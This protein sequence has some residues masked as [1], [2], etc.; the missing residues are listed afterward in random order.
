MGDYPVNVTLI[1]SIISINPINLSLIESIKAMSKRVTLQDIADLAGVGVATVDRVINDRAPVSE[2]TAKRVLDAANE[3]SFHAQELMRH[4][5]HRLG[6]E[7]RLSFILQKQSKWFYQKLASEI[8][9]AAETQSQARVRA[10]IRFVGSLSADALISEIRKL[11]AQSD[12]IA[13][14]SIDHPSI[15][16]EIEACRLDGVPV[17]AL[18]SPLN[19]NVKCPY[20]GIDGRKAG[21]TAGWAMAR[22]ADQGEIGILVGS[23]RYLGHEA[24]EVGFR[25][26]MREHRPNTRLRDSIVYLD[27]EAIAYEAASELLTTCPKL[28][29]LYHCGGGVGGVVKALKESAIERAPTYICHEVGPSARAGLIDGLI[30]LA[31]ATPIEALARKAVAQMIEA[32]LSKQA[33]IA[34]AI[35]DFMPYTPESI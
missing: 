5:V 2:K 4:R 28:K 12:A 11:K 13:L 19:P 31:I 23:H 6:P 21:R 9:L 27:D 7:L 15:A 18:L 25:S 1:D 24:L 26:Y 29:G 33:N 16:A 14:V 34:D 17:F 8:A 30:D 32:R 22:I 10:D 35:L 20:I 3:L